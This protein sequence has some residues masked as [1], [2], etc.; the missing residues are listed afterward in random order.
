MT[1]T[2]QRTEGEAIEE[3]DTPT[4]VIAIESRPGPDGDWVRRASTPALP[5]LTFEAAT[6]TEAITLIDDAITERFGSADDSWHWLH[7]ARVGPEAVR[8]PAWRARYEQGR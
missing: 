2:V 3:I 5:D 6:L 7:F 4:L 1:G 8:R